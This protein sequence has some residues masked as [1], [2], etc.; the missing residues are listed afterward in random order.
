MLENCMSNSVGRMN[1]SKERLISEFYKLQEEE[2]SQSVL[3]WQYLPKT[4]YAARL[5]E[6]H[7]VPY[8]ESY[9]RRILIYHLRYAKK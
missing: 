7:I 2:R 3:R 8:T 9:I 1:E 4:Y 6:M 5:F